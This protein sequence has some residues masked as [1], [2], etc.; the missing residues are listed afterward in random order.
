M[1]DDLVTRQYFN[2]M[3]PTWFN[4]AAD[5]NN[6]SKI[7]QL[8]S[9]ISFKSGQKILDIGCGTGVLFPF[10]SKLTKNQSHIVALDYAFAMTQEA[11]T[12]NIQIINTLC[13]DAHFLPFQD[14]SFDTIIAFHVFPHINQK[15]YALQEWKRVLKKGGNLAIIHLK[16][17]N[18]LNSFHKTL[19]S[20]VRHHLQP[21]GEKMDEL[22]IQA[23]YV[24]DSIIDKPDEYFVNAIK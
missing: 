22:L 15:I 7:I 23:R 5:S 16:G 6:R 20:P 1:N 19:D 21:S 8:L 13:S 14:N 10:L 11:A 18:E 12:K 3:A 17:S 2:N 24:I 4:V 9:R